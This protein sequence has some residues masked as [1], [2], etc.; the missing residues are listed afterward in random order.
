[1]GRTSVGCLPRDPLTSWCFRDSAGHKQAL[2]GGADWDLRF[3]DNRY[4]LQGTAAFTHQQWS[5]D[6]SPGQTGFGGQLEA[7]KRQG[8]VSRSWAPGIPI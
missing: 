4:G 7:G 5:A 2:T 1:M 6:Q 3:Q 8:S